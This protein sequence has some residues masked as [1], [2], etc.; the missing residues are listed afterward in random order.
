MTT[1]SLFLNRKTTDDSGTYPVISLLSVHGLGN[2]VTY[3]RLLALATLC[4]VGA[5][6]T[7]V[8][9]IAHPHHRQL[10]LIVYGIG[11]IPFILAIRKVW[12]SYRGRSKQVLSW[13]IHIFVGIVF[14][15]SAWAFKVVIP[16]E[17]SPLLDVE[18][19]RLPLTLEADLQRLAFI[20]SKMQGALTE[21]QKSLLLE[22]IRLST[23]ESVEL[24]AQWARFVEASVE[25]DLLKLQYRAFYQ[26]NGFTHPKLQAQAFL[27]AYGAHVSQYR[28]AA[29]VTTRIGNLDTVKN[30]LD[31]A[32]RRRDFRREVLPVFSSWSAILTR[33][34][35]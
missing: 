35:G 3:L 11:W 29:F 23:D 22:S 1:S 24:G 32:I 16:L 18:M 14:F 4:A 31:D 17:R 2:R 5:F 7:L 13:K 19:E 20:D 27:I 25:L 30:L 10:S 6:V 8:L 33:F 12:I 34:F 9:R 15:V 26:V 28:A 21:L